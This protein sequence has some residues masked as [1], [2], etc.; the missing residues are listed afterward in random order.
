MDIFL[1]IRHISPTGN[2]ILYTGTT[3]D[4]VPPTKGWL[5]V[6]LRKVNEKHP[7]HRP[8]LPHR[9]YFSTD[10]Q[11][12]QKDEIYAVDVEIWPTNFVVEKGGRIVFELSSGDTQGTGI[13]LHNSPED[14]FVTQA[15][16]LGFKQLRQH[17]LT[18][19][20]SQNVF[21]GLNNLHFAPGTQNYVTLPIIPQ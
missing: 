10:V 4:A 15:V 16:L 9:D 12:V 2:E 17:K 3:G 11:S 8:W 1:A 5:R 6:S 13:F 21:G 14:R 7:K 20:R 18:D 19:G